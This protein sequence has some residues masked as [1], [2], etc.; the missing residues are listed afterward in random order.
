MSLKNLISAIDIDSIIESDIKVSDVVTKVI[1]YFKKYGYFKDVN[2]SD[3][4]IGDI[5]NA[6]KLFQELAGLVI[7]GIIGP[8]TYRALSWPRCGCPDGHLV[9]LDYQLEV[10]EA[11][12]GRRSLVFYIEQRDSDLSAQEWDSII[13]KAFDQ[14]A[15]VANL[16][17]DITR[18]K[19]K[20]NF[21]MSTG[22]GRAFGFDG[23][24]GTL[25]WAQLPPNNNYNGQL[26]CRF[27]ES[28][29]WVK[30]STQRGIILL[31]V[32]CHEVGHLLGLEHSRN[33]NDLMAPFYKPGISKPQNG[34]I[35]RIQGLYGPPQDNPSPEPQ[36]PTPEPKP[37]TSFP[38]PTNLI[39]KQ[40]GDNQVLLSWQDNSTGENGFQ[41][42]RADAG[43]NNWVT[44]GVVGRG[45]TR[46]IDT[47]PGPG[48][49]KYRVRAFT[50]DKQSDWSNFAVV[51]VKSG[52]SPN[53][54]PQ[55]P[56]DGVEIKIEGKIDKITI[57][58]YRV[59][60]IG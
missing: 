58:G 23:S 2:I 59:N 37:P 26:L 51:S 50:N 38:A 36:P 57:P 29:T 34:D 5:I 54:S 6:V 14:W 8:K 13:T 27:D 48:Y 49:Y 12:W 17:F 33:S 15:D 20:A 31:N 44:Q 32:A 35:K 4:T 21:I 24:G 52:D 3:I 41:I 45:M 47:V 11:K 30:D 46:A 1:E 60:K 56:T 40:Q 42:Q 16:K 7:D 39:A 25:A 18:N 9:K 10:L 28:E 53:P 19:S 22:R 43:T 55:P